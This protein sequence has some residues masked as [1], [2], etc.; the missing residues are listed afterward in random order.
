MT[1]SDEAGRDARARARPDRAAGGR[2]GDPVGAAAERRLRSLAPDRAGRPRRSR[3]RGVPRP[4]TRVGHIRERAEDRAG[5]DDDVVHGGHAPA[6]DEPASGTLELRTV[7]GRRSPRAPAPRLAVGADRRRDAATARGRRDMAIETLHVRA[8]RVPGSQA[9]DLEERSFYELLQDRYGIEIVT[10]LQTVEPTVTGEDES[11]PSAC[12]CIRP[13]S[14]SSASRG[15]RSGEIVEF[16]GSMYRGDRYRLVTAFR[17]RTSASAR[18]RSR[19]ASVVGSSLAWL[20]PTV[21]PP[22]KSAWLTEQAFRPQTSIDTGLTPA[23]I[24]QISRRGKWY[25][26][27]WCPNRFCDVSRPARCGVPRCLWRCA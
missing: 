5:A 24:V 22:L 7:A 10:G 3:A 2:R 23:E 8:S 9:R 20:I 6:R 18:G 21:A 27:I 1:P 16:V 15:R 17:R 19:R 11:R 4:A 13:R 25:K 26:P 14:S 12:R